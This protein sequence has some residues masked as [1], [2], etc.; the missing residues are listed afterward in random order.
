[1]STLPRVLFVDHTG[2]LG[3]GELSLFDLADRTPGCRVMLFSDGPFRA[4]LEAAGVATVLASTAALDGVKRDGGLLGA[5]GAVGGVWKMARQLAREGRSADVLYAN[6]LKSWV[7]TAIAGF[8]CRKPTVWHL[9]DILSDAHFSR[10]NIRVVVMLANRFSSLV[11]ANSQATADAFVAAGGRADCIRVIYNGIDPAPY[12]ANRAQRDASRVD[13]DR[14]LTVACVGRLSPW[15]GQHVFLEAIVKTPGVVGKV[16]GAPLFGED[17]YAA[18]LKRDA[19]RLGIAERVEF[20]GFQ[21][22]IPEILGQCDILAHTSTAPE[23]FGRV[24]VEAMLGGLAIVATRG[25]GPSEIIRDGQTGILTTPSDPTELAAALQQ[26]QADP[27]RRRSLAAAGREDAMKR[28]T[29]DAVIQQVHAALMPFGPAATPATTKP[30]P[31]KPADPA[32]PGRP[33][34]EKPEPG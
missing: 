12:A 27:D 20:M 9:R 31:G 6:S 23:P 5:V 15:K 11:I 17:A 32:H 4:M 8:M 33:P 10:T 21:S 29:L 7:V 34:Q 22:N 3:G 14:P 19:E 16:I 2:Q 18:R 28:F 30:T 13:N 25:G 26:L 24:I 1:M